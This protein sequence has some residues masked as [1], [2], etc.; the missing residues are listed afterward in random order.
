VVAA[1][2][3]GNSNY[4]AAAQ[5]TQ[6]ITVNKIAP[7]TGLTASPNPVL[8][9]NA[10]TLTATVASSI[11]TPTGSVT[12]SDS[13]TTLGTANLSGGIATLSSSTLAAGSHSITATYSG[14]G[15]FTSVSSTAVSETVEDFTLTIGG[16][17][18]SQTVQPGGT[19]TYTLPI[20]PSGG[21]T[22]PAAVTFSASSVPTGF[23]ATF[24]PSS[25]PTGS[26]ATNVA[27]MIQVPLSAMLEKSRQPGK[28][29]PMVALGILVLPFVAGIKRSS[30]GLRRLALIVMIV[31]GIGG[32]STLTGCGGGGGSSGSGGSQ[33]QTYNITVT[34]T[35]GTLSHSTTVALTVQ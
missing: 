4:A 19:A 30:N 14:D 2:Q 31:A 8:V 33:P 26:S 21:T 13:G 15:N 7:S 1:N 24:S 25:L 20:A 23:T 17:G 5:M 34:A 6:S 27:L 22:F 9:Q 28:G 32:L 29:L 3:S 18:S 16:S 11:G 12:F 35:S 10:V